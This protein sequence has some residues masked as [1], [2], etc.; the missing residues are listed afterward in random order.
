M[1]RLISGMQPSTTEEWLSVATARGADAEA[2]F[3][4]HPGSIGSVY[5]MGYGVECS[6][7]AYL[8]ATRRPFP[9]SGRAGHDLTALWRASGFSKRDIQDKD[10]NKAF[11]FEDWSTDLRYYTGGLR[12][13]NHGE[14]LASAKKV[15]GW[16]H[17]QARRE[18]GR[19]RR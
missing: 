8:K 1:E 4:K 15:V 12:Q 18:H 5:L 13:L 16:L 6:I 10:G 17:Q 19:G 9:T 3:E 11:Y 7:K 2:V 14:L